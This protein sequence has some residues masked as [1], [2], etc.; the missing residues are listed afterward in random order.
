MS[1]LCP[2]FWHCDSVYGEVILCFGLLTFNCAYL[3]Y[4]ALLLHTVIIVYIYY[5]RIYFVDYFL[6]HRAAWAFNR[7]ML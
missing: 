6:L 4:R 1:D 2:W 3:L 5:T 7:S